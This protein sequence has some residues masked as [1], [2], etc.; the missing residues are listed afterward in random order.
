MEDLGR[1]LPKGWL[2]QFDSETGHQ[3]Y[4]D[5]H[6]ERSIW[7]HPYDDAEYMQSLPEKERERIAALHPMPSHADIAA[8]SSDDDDDGNAAW[9]AEQSAKKE[10]LTRPPK[11]KDGISRRMKN[12]LTGTTHEEREVER[13]K[14]AKEEQRAYELHMAVRR[15][16]QKAVETGKPVKIMRNADGQDIY[17]EPPGGNSS[18]VGA[19]GRA[20]NPS[21]DGPYSDPNAR[22]FRPVEGYN[23]G[24][25]NYGY[26]GTGQRAPATVGSGFRGAGTYGGYGGY[27]GG[28][29]GYGRGYGGGMGLYVTR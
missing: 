2:R 21:R 5:S 16:M 19:D 18:G 26:P 25:G 4:V 27:G 13:A 6:T 12:K 22:F 23:R 29:G 3:F 10:D 1:E 9:L 8:E 28:Y 17:I 14:R 20:Y 24:Y 11:Q 15:G 7:H